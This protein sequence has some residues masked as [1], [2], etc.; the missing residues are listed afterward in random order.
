MVLGTAIASIPASLLVRR[1]GRAGFLVGA[2][3]GVTGSAFAAL[4]IQSGSFVVFVFGHLLLGN[5]QGFANYYRFAAARQPD[6][7][8][9]GARSPGSSPA[10]S[11]RTGPQIAIWGRDWMLPHLFLGSYVAQGALSFVALG[12]IALLK[13]P[14]QRRPAASRHGRCRDCEPACAAGRHRKFWRLVTW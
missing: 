8:T 5:Y 4:G 6:P 7:P 12:L 2:G 1:I 3:L 13:L 10:A 11:W 14:R 9:W